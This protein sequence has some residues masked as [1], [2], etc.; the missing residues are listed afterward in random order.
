MSK[1]KYDEIKRLLD[2]TNMTRPA[3]AAAT[4][5]SVSQVRSIHRGAKP[6]WTEK[7][8]DDPKW[9]RNQQERSEKQ[10][11]RWKSKIDR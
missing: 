9:M 7:V 5:V 1:R 11:K 4:G 6:R 8:P 3:I 2:N 10:Y